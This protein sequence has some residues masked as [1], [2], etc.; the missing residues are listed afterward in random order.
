[1]SAAAQQSP[2]HATSRCSA[3]PP[4]PVIPV[5]DIGAGGPLELVRR[6]RP[7]ALALMEAAHRQFTGPLVRAADWRGR[8][9]LVRAGNP[10]LAEIDAIARELGR[11]GAHGLNLS[12]E[13]ACT[14]GVASD[15]AG[16]TVLRRTL[17]WPFHGLGRNTVVARRHGVAGPW[18]DI[19]WPG[20]VGV[21]TA[22]APGRFAAA[23]NQ[24]PLRRR[25][26][27]MAADWLIDR[28]RVGRSTDLPPC[29]LLR[30]VFETCRDYAEARN[31][32]TTSPICLPAL[33]ILAGAKPGEGCIIE[34]TEGAA[35]IVDA[36][37]SIANDWLTPAF[38]RGTPRGY[39]SPTR[40]CLLAA[41]QAGPCDELEWLQPPIANPFTRLA[42]VLEPAAGR[43]TL[44]GWER[45][46][47]ATQILHL[48]PSN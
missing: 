36:P 26:G 1:V 5:I 28:V 17:D 45:S 14:A 4:L 8:R 30:E 29:H 41:C 11:P 22:L 21:F 7:Q 48:Q 34:R 39:D 25:T 18:L 37:A 19:T 20:F 13:W 3:P 35:A 2:P 33:F 42:A 23:I 27:L 10:H 16:N 12:Y 32:L 38:G 46:G 15:A 40:Q 9:W 24:A 43:L 44:Q 47:P 31:L 6:A